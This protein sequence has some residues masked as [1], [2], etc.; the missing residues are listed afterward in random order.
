MLIL[1]V[2]FS[3][4]TTQTH[5]H[6]GCSFSAVVMS[7]FKVN[8]EICF[9]RKAIRKIIQ[10]GRNLELED[11]IRM[12]AFTL[13]AVYILYIKA[14]IECPRLSQSACRMLGELANQHQGGGNLTLWQ[15]RSSVRSN[16]KSRQYH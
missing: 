13:R 16:I 12:T 10:F 11:K 3:C 6:I 7:R 4:R 5:P 15:T 2:T 14:S 9:R 1:Q 8:F